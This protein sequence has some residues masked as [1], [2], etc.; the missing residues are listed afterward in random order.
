[1]QLRHWTVQQLSLFSTCRISNDAIDGQ[2][3]QQFLLARYVREQSISF[4]STTHAGTA[5]DLADGTL[6]W[7]VG[8]VPSWSAALV[9]GS[10]VPDTHGH[11]ECFLESR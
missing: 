8:P 5:K 1:M 6:H 7:V 11:G 2:I 10:P 9:G 4:C 3:A